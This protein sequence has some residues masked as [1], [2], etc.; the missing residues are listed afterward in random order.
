MLRATS[1]RAKE[2]SLDPTLHSTDSTLV[3]CAE[4]FAPIC[5]ACTPGTQ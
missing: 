2:N 1:T 5:T 4:Q 3:R